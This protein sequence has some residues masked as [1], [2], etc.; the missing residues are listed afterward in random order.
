M[1]FLLINHNYH[2]SE[3]Q[4]QCDCMPLD[5]PGY[6]RIQLQMDFGCQCCGACCQA[7]DPIEIV[8]EIWF[9]LAKE[10]RLSLKN[11]DDD[12]SSDK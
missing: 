2:A 10:F 11:A 6:L 8:A 7:K 3:W 5:P 1:V 12:E 4:E 9:T